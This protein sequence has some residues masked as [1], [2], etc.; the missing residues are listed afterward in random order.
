MQKKSTLY[1][2]V[3]KSAQIPPGQV[4]PRAVLGERF[5][6]V[7][8]QAGN[9]TRLVSFTTVLPVFTDWF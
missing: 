4:S 8:E 6:H 5:S 1:C 2:D 7:R 3:I 9:E